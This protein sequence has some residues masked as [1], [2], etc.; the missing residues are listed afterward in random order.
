LTAEHDDLSPGERP[1]PVTSMLVRSIENDAATGA[2]RPRTSTQSLFENATDR[3]QSIGIGDD[4]FALAA[5]VPVA[6]AIAVG[7]RAQGHDLGA[8]TH[9]RS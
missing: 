2:R 6:H 4:A 8:H 5:Q 1:M 7:Q 3:L 9:R